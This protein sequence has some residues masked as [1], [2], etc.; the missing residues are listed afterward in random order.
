VITIETTLLE[1]VLDT[2]KM[3][4]GMGDKGGEIQNDSRGSSIQT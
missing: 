3:R 1:D 2:K 4:D